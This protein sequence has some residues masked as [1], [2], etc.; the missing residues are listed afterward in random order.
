MIG[1]TIVSVG[2]YQPAR[3]LDNDELSRLVDT[4]DEWITRR[5]GIA[6]RRV[7]APDETVADMA[8][9][10]A[11]DALQDKGIDPAG[12][13]LVIVAT[14]TN[15]DRSPST[16]AQVARRL[17]LGS[18]PAVMD[19]NAVCSGFCHALAL[20]EQA[21]ATGS[22][23]RAVVVGVDKFTDF[24]DWN[25]RTTCILVGDGAGAV[26]LEAS[27][28]RGVSPVVWGS[29]PEMGDAVVIK[30]L[31]DGFS[32]QGQAVFRWTTTQ[33]PAIARQI[34][35]RADVAPSD[36]A[37]IVLHQANLR[38][39]EPLAAKIGATDAVVSTDVVESGN[40]SAASVPLALSKLVR[41]GRVASGAPILL[42]G[43]GGGLAYAGQVV[44]CP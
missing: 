26:V 25:D 41:S 9:E 24:I 43:F 10:A 17:G 36:L 40:T 4:S 42:F 6:Q 37:G 38:I 14:C 21:I 31:P 15:H 13:D 1:S 7:A 34:C 39:I 5:V 2:H 33:L 19:V 18:A 3:I 23:T 28:E 44:R 12:I 29:V 27:P 32:Q 35:E 22:A 16:A 11:R 20:A 8:T 30:E